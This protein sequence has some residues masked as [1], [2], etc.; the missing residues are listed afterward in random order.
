MRYKHHFDDDYTFA[1]IDIELDIADGRGNSLPA[2][3]TNF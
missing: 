2:N 3:A 1:S